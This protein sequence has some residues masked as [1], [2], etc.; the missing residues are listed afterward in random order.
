MLLFV[1]SLV[2]SDE[3]S[4]DLVKQFPHLMP[5]MVNETEVTHFET[6]FRPS[7][8]EMTSCLKGE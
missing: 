7:D 1:F 5:D 8:S 3:S 2:H 4:D 6:D